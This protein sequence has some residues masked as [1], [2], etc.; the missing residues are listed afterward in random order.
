M[1][2]HAK[3]IVL[4]VAATVIAFGVH[5]TLLY[6]TGNQIIALLLALTVGAINFD[7]AR[8]LWLSK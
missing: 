8:R 5:G 3:S 2:D 6:L 1:T 7:Q 4:V